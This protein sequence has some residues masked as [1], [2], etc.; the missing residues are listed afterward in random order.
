MRE[1]LTG[2]RQGSRALKRGRVCGNGIG[3]GSVTRTAAVDGN[4]T[5]I[6]GGTP[7]TSAG[8][9]GYRDVSG[10]AAR[11]RGSAGWRDGECTSHHYR[12]DMDSYSGSR[13]D[14]LRISGPTTE[15][16]NIWHTRT[17]GGLVIR[18][19][20]PSTS[21]RRHRYWFR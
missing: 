16:Y 15:S 13:N 8:T 12:I 3:C 20:R 11:G 5:R 6:A 9:R 4:P 14:K 10:S 21:C 1:G 2:D 18:F 7:W 17:S 19:A